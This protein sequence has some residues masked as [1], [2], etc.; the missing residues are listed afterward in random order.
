[1]RGCVCVC[2]CG[3]VAVVVSETYDRAQTAPT[4]GCAQMIGIKD[5]SSGSTWWTESLNTI[6]NVKLQKEFLSVGGMKA[7]GTYFNASLEERTAGVISEL[8]QDACA[9][10]AVLTGF[11]VNPNHMDHLRWGK[12][13]E[14][15]PRAVPVVWDRS[16]S[17]KKAISQLLYEQ[18]ACRA[19]NP[20]NATAAENC[21]GLALEY[22]PKEFLRRVQKA[23]CDSARLY[24]TAKALNLD[25]RTYAMTYE[26]FRIDPKNETANL[27]SALGL[28][29][30]PVIDHYETKKRTFKRTPEDL[31]NTFLNFDDIAAKL[32]EWQPLDC[33]LEDMLRDTRGKPFRC[34]PY[35]VCVHLGAI[36]FSF[37]LRTPEEQML[38]AGSPEVRLGH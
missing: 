27:F 37:A 20:N 22:S 35:Q 2:L 26:A 14:R 21:R 29:P 25:A 38:K 30:A 8:S 24:S 18:P 17:V 16:N 12:V 13:V 5:S 10:G 6:P 36:D 32:R 31:R 34:D 4:P 9:R 19:H 15:R 33:P 1:M 11:T 28:D 23:V 7:H 3:L